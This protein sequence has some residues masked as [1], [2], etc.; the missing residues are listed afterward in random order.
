[1][2][3]SFHLDTSP[4]S[5]TALKIMFQNMNLR[6][7]VGGHIQVI[8]DGAVNEDLSVTPFSVVGGE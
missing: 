4:P 3:Q 1:M 6:C 8:A 7:G 2:T 5:I